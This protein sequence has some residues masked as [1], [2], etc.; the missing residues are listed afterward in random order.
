MSAAMSAGTAEPAIGAAQ[1]TGCR[2]TPV[3]VLRSEWS[4][5]W[6]LRSTWITLAACTVM[7]LAMGAVAGATYSPDGDRMSDPVRLSLFGLNFTQ[8]AAAVLGVLVTAGEYT[9][10]MARATFAA[11]PRRLPVLWAKAAVFGTTLFALTLPTVLLTFPLAQHFLSGTE[12]HA[13][14]GDPGV[15]RSLLGSAAN[16][17][18]VGVLGLALGSLLRSAPGGIGVF[19]G[20]LLVLPQTATLLPSDWADSVPAYAPSSA[21]EAMMSLTPRAHE[22][23]PEAGLA[24]L[25]GWVAVALGAAAFRLVRQDV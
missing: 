9:T 17:A 8:L 1:L 19:V 12:M 13:S 23:S 22:L 7:T 24:V 10:G 16:L 18:L 20:G 2:V 6:S 3:R 5:L 21:G 4:K 14:F 25:C 11:V 15:L